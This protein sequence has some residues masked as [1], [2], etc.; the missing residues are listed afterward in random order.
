INKKIIIL[1]LIFFFNFLLVNNTL[2]NEKYYFLT[3]KYNKVKVRQGPSF[4]YPVKFIYKKKYL[5]IKVIN[6]KDNF[7]KIIDLKNNDGWIHVSQ[8]TKKKSAIN[9]YNLSI[10]Y[11]KPN[12][13]SQP[14]AKLEKGKIVIVKKCK[15]DWCKIVIDGYKGW[16]FKNYLWGN[17]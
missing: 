15:E 12:I 10:I 11:K 4:E 1:I 16:I 8:L 9:I 3:L 7:K 5:P 13:Y 6:S 14:M 2:S 17:L